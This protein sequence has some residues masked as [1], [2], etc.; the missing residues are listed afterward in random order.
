MFWQLQCNL[1]LLFHPGPPRT[2]WQGPRWPLHKL[3]LLKSAPWVSPSMTL[4]RQKVHLPVE[5][6]S[7]H[8]LTHG[9]SGPRESTSQTA[10]RSV[11][12]VLQD[13]RL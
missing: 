10:F 8:R 13:S 2:I 5:D 1:L 3:P 7:P 9:S 6:S 4:L 11:P 12:P